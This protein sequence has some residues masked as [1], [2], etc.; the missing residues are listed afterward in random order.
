ME[1]IIVPVNTFIDR[2][3]VK[4]IILEIMTISFKLNQ[5]QS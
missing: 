3:I 5:V 1:N 4:D 2:G